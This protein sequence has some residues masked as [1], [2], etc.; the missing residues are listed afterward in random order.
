MADAVLSPSRAAPLARMILAQTRL[1][2]KLALR[3]G[4]RCHA[5]RPR[6]GRIPWLMPS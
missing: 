5:H 4:D 2:I 6:R 3:R 1:E